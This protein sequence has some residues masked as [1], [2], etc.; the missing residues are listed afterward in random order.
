MEVSYFLI[1][2]VVVVDEPVAVV[3]QADINFSWRRLR[4][5]MDA[6]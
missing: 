5:S 2:M 6:L 1:Q 3:L 4:W